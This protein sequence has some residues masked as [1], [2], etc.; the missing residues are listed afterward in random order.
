MYTQRGFGWTHGGFFSVPYHTAHTPRTQPHTATAAATASNTWS[1][2]RGER[3]QER[4]SLI[5]FLVMRQVR[6]NRLLLGT[7]AWFLRLPRLRPWWEFHF[8]SHKRC[9]QKPKTHQ[10]TTASGSE[11]HKHTISDHK[12]HGQTTME[13]KTVAFSSFWWRTSN[14]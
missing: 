13:G 1:H 2:C 3:S 9:K 7:A 5:L 6:W 10:V 11:N 14:I 12:N 8:P 4:Q